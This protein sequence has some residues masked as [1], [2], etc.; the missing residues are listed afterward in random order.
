MRFH[1]IAPSSPA[2]T[3]L[4]VT[5]SCTTNP[6]LTAFATAVLPRKTAAKLKVADQMT[7]ANGLST[8]VPTI[9]AMAFAES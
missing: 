3:T 9:V 5:M 1:V 6:L 7:A 8:R 4:G 2:Q